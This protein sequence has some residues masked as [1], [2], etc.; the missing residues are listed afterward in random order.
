MKN[1]SNVGTAAAILLGSL[2]F[3]CL[4]QQA[5]KLLPF[6]G[7][8][9]DQNGTAVSD[10]VRV[11]Q[12]K[13]YDAPVGGQAVWNGEVQKLTVN[14]GLVSTVLGSKASLSSVDFNKS[15][16][17]ELT[18]DA[19]NDNQITSAD[20]PMLPRQAIVP[21]VFS[22]ESADSRLLANYDWSALF[23]TNNPANGTLLDSKI[24]DGSISAAKIQPGT[25]SSN[26]IAPQAINASLIASGTITS[27][28]IGPSAI[29][30]AALASNA[31]TMGA[32]APGAVG[33]AQLASNSISLDKFSSR[34]V[35]TNVPVGGFAQ[36][37]SSGNF[38]GIGDVPNLAVTITTAGR[39][40]FVGLI[41]DGDTINHS[42]V[43]PNP[44]SFGA[45]SADF[46]FTRDSAVIGLTF[47][48]VAPDYYFLIPPGAFYHLD[49]P[50]PG[51]HTYTF[52]VVDGGSPQVQYVRLI[53]YE[54]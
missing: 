11:V 26:Q 47:M 41:A 18:I 42:F 16:Y 45:V 50:P 8:L 14:G 19:N 34:M 22:K 12:F 29:T 25:I 32:I 44:S 21:A 23:G 15:L 27:N 20:P 35:G 2:A 9:S 10:G 3:A 13:I 7:R 48:L 52:R 40:V 17:L 36:S 5:P 6:Q 49:T 33:A 28:Q 43:G 46:A 31:V 4:G 38:G 53:A 37:G 39:P 24:R 51:M 1:T 54:L 30:T